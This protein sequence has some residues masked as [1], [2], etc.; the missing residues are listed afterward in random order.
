MRTTHVAFGV[1][2]IGFH[3]FFLTGNDVNLRDR[4]FCTVDR[5]SERFQSW[6]VLRFLFSS[7]VIKSVFVLWEL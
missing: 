4:K 1:L 6:E 2:D 3:L 5:V 7:E